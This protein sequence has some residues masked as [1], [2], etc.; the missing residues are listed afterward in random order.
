MFSSLKEI[1]YQGGIL[2]FNIPKDWVE[3]Y[4]DEDG[5]SFYEDSPT[6]GTLRVKLLTM[7]SPKKLNS[8]NVKDILAPIN[9]EIK[10]LP[11]KNAY[12]HYHKDTI[13]S[14]HQITI[15][16]WSLA[17]IIAPNN[18]RLVNFS[19]TILSDKKELASVKNEISFL[20]QQI[21]KASLSPELTPYG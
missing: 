4:N 7:E 16:Y 15:F 12:K 21:Q 5:G 9:G 14:G 20:T 13:E 3:E 17:Q 10:I 11:N 2:K 18:A 1:I 19:Y 6:S 8:E